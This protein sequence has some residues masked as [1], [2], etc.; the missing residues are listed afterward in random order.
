MRSIHF[1]RLAAAAGLIAAS[2]LA[3]AQEAASAPGGSERAPLWNWTYR[4]CVEQSAARQFPQGVARAEDLLSLAVQ[5]RRDCADRVPPPGT[6]L[7][8]LTID[9]VTAVVR[10]DL[11]RL[12]KT[13][14]A[15]VA[16]PAP[17][18]RP[19]LRIGEGG[20]CPQPDYP[21]AAVRAMVTGSTTVRLR[22]D[23]DGSVV[24]GDIANASGP[25]R[26]HRLLDGTAVDTFSRCKFPA[27]GLA[28]TVS[29]RFDWR[30]EP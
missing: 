7:S 19:P 15:A 3:H 17:A 8:Q 28:R 18:P 29:L 25:T 27:I 9:S 6:D 12:V 23:A 21:P 24:G 11:S 16:T 30:I 20:V 1:K 13:S 14:P 4:Q 10:S 22:I 2:S 26:E 5:V